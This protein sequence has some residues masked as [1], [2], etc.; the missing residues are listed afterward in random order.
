MILASG[1]AYAQGWS[2]FGYAPQ[3]QPSFIYN[4]NPAGLYRLYFNYHHVRK[5]HSRYKA[6]APRPLPLQE[7]EKPG[8]YDPPAAGAGPM[9]LFVNDPTLRRG[10][11]VVTSIGVRV[12]EG[13][14]G[15][16]HAA[17]DFIAL[18]NAHFS[19]LKHFVELTQ[20]EQ[21]NRKYASRFEVAEV[22][23]NANDGN[24]V[25]AKPKNG[26]VVLQVHRR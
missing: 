5:A 8:P 21:S 18:S 11:I 17:R 20:I 25:E 2:Y 12:F 24:A 6:K 14:R 16:A 15:D 26:F 19:N 1:N 13:S 9:G 10:D 23:V 3:T 7:A 4:P 22:T